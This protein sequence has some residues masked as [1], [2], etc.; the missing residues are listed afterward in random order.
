MSI[1]F[2]HELDFVGGPKDP[3]ILTSTPRGPVGDA[4]V[5]RVWMPTL[6]GYGCQHW[7]GPHANIGMVGV[8]T[9]THHV[10][11]GR[12]GMPTLAG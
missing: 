12:V 11:I 1:A 4:N 9:L 10:N 2:L 8:P 7:H 5:G 3:I 6:A